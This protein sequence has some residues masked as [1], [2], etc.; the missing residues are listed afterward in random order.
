MDNFIL[1]RGTTLTLY[2]YN[3]YTFDEAYANANKTKVNA[4][5][6]GNSITY[7]WAKMRPEFFHSHGLINGGTFLGR[8]ISPKKKP[9]RSFPKNK[10]EGN[11]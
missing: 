10:K 4:V 3:P 6:Y 7:N 2:A 8:T 9:K 5:F 11:K 1:L